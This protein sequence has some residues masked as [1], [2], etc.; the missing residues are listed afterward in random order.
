MAQA[1][2][3]RARIKRMGD[4]FAAC[5]VGVRPPEDMVGTPGIKKLC[6]KLVPGQVIEV[7]A[8]HNLL[9]QKCVEIVRDVERDEIL[10][11]WVFKS[12]ADALMANP[13]KSRLGAEAIQASL[14]LS[15]GAV[16][17]QARKLAARENAREN[18]GLDAAEPLAGARSGNTLQDRLAA[19]RQDPRYVQSVEDENAALR[20]QL[21]AAKAVASTSNPAVQPQPQYGGEREE[22]TESADED[23]SEDDYVPDT[24]NR[25]SSEEAEEI[26]G[27]PRQPETAPE[28]ASDP[29][30]APRERRK[31]AV[32]FGSR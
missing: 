25:L 13:S 18:A 11:P 12:A 23:W 9:R 21:E 4:M 27:K 5:G 16:D 22:G 17:H 30:P 1:R 31:R 26:T 6:P 15:Q 14:A 20:A 3:V 24:Q 29:A 8:N 2:T 28:P 32:N 10:R 19:R 7:P